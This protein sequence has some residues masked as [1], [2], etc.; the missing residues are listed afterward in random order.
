[1]SLLCVGCEG[2][3]MPGAQVRHRDG[4]HGGPM[5]DAPRDPRRPDTP[6]DGGDQTAPLGAVPP[7]DPARPVPTTYAPP[8]AG[9]VPVPGRWERLRERAWSL[10]AVLAVAL[11]SVLLGSAGG[12]AL[13]SAAGGEDAGRGGPGGPGGRHG[14]NGG[15]PGFGRQGGATQ[16]GQQGGFGQ[17][18][19]QGGFGP[20]GQQGQQGGSGQQGQVPQQRTP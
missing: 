19:Q 17:Q 18:G 11:A 1:M 7:H 12:A 4:R 14:F 20:Q 16:Q 9:A 10:R 15:P 8:G 5:D 13:A 3:S 6:A 2:W